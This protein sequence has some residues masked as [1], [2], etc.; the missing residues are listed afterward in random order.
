MNKFIDEGVEAGYDFIVIEPKECYNESIVA[1]DRGSLVY[2]VEKLMDCTRR[3][4]EWEY[5]T[6]IEWFEYNTLSLTYMKGG[7]LFFEED[8]EFYLTH[9]SNRV[10]IKVRNKIMEDK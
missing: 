2:D 1:F 3:Y 10:T 5:E 6:A 8:E 9:D 4:Y 7:P